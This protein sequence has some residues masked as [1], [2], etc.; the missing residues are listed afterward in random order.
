MSCYLGRLEE[1]IKQK[2]TK[3]P[4][5]YSHD[6]LTATRR[7]RDLRTIRRAFLIVGPVMTSVGII[8]LFAAFA[9]VYNS[10]S[11]SRESDFAFLLGFGIF[12]VVVGILLIV[13]ALTIVKKSLRKNE[14]ILNMDHM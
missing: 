7:V 11:A 14:K 9:I 5:I 13:L 6:Y 3:M 10:S 12:T 8:V 4:D 2:G 1:C